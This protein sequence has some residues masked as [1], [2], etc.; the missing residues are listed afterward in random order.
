MEITKTGNIKIEVNPERKYAGQFVGY[1]FYHIMDVAKQFPSVK[2]F[3][4]LP[5]DGFDLG[6]GATNLEMIRHHVQPFRRNGYICE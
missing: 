4:S 5:D 2:D 1:E 6:D 3:D